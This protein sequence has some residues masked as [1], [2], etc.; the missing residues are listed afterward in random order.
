MSV[1]LVNP[2]DTSF[3]TAVITPRWLFVLAAATAK[4]FGDPE[5]C[6]ETLEH[7]N[8]ERVQ[9][10]DFLGIGIHTGIHMRIYEVG[11]PAHQ[12]VACNLFHINHPTPIPNIH[13]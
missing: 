4:S 13:I 6:D 8:L 2:S 9:P 3:G 5:I 11:R 10:G 7:L 12:R 1:H